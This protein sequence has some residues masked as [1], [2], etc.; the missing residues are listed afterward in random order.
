MIASLDRL[1]VRGWGFWLAWAFVFVGFPLGA[2]AG[3]AVAGPIDSPSRGLMAGAATGLVVGG[4]QWIV[5]RRRL[6]LPVMWVL[7]TTLGLAVG[8]GLSI[9]LFGSENSATL[10]LSRALMTGGV[11]GAAQAWVLRRFGWPAA[12]WALVVT[13]AWVLGWVITSAVGVDL[14]P[15]WSVFGSTGAWAF[16]FVTGLTLAWLIRRQPGERPPAL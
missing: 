9:W 15:K 6:A 5:I 13:A 1:P 11:L 12:A 3:Q 4:L 8:L 10:V 16:Q 14:G 7:A 2:L